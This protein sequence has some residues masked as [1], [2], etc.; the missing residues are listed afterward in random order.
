MKSLVRRDYIPSSMFPKTDHEFIAHI[1]HSILSSQPGDS[2]PVF[3]L[4]VVCVC[5][6]HTHTYTSYFYFLAFLSTS[7]IQHTHTSPTRAAFPLHVHLKRVSG[8]E[9]TSSQQHQPT[10]RASQHQQARGKPGQNPASSVAP[11]G[12]SVTG[13]ASKTSSEGTERLHVHPGG[14]RL[15]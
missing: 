7:D 3:S 14:N 8:G 15:T 10:G 12:R 1:D 2:R 11:R 13:S 6:L 5:V 9:I 4:T